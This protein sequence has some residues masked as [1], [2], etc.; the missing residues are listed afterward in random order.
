MSDISGVEAFQQSQK[1]EPKIIPVPID[2][3]AEAAANRARVNGDGPDRF[4]S[5]GFRFVLKARDNSGLEAWSASIEAGTAEWRLEGRTTIRSLLSHYCATIAILGTKSLRDHVSKSLKLNDPLEEVNSLGEDK[6][7]QFNP[8]GIVSDSGSVTT[9]RA[10][11]FK[12]AKKRL[13]AE[14]NDA[15]AAPTLRQASTCAVLI[16]NGWAEMALFAG[17]KLDKDDIGQAWDGSDYDKSKQSLGVA[18]RACD[19]GPVLYKVATNK[20]GEVVRLQKDGKDIVDRKNTDTT[21]FYLNQAQA[22]ALYAWRIDG[23]TLK[24]ECFDARGY[25]DKY[26]APRDVGGDETDAEAKY[27]KIVGQKVTAT[28]TFKASEK[29]PLHV[30]MQAAIKKMDNPESKMF[31]DGA[32]TV[33]SIEYLRSQIGRIIQQAETEADNKGLPHFSLVMSFLDLAIDIK[34]H[35]SK[36]NERQVAFY[37][38]TPKGAE[39]MVE[40]RKPTLLTLPQ[41]VTQGGEESKTGTTNYTSL[42]SRAAPK[43]AALFFCLVSVTNLYNLLLDR[44]L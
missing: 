32:F 10:Q 17:K 23:Q 21:L 7:M 11:V 16:A 29:D 6:P 33:T 1:R 14:A 39:K 41:E 36:R 12:E 37:G 2:N 9:Y 18:V 42:P 43:G 19:L 27:A 34:E 24:D 8:N 20:A 13:K 30:A 25:L 5:D 38:Y 31:L 44:I 15:S 26:V 22:E 3:E 28:E 35:F 4:H 40:E